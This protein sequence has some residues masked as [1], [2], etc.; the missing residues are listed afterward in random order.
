MQVLAQVGLLRS[1]NVTE[2]RVWWSRT[3]AKKSVWQTFFI[4]LLNGGESWWSFIHLF[5]VSGTQCWVQN[6]YFYPWST[7]FLKIKWKF[8]ELSVTDPACENLHECMPTIFMFNI[9]VH[10]TRCSL[11]ARFLWIVASNK[12]SLR[13]PILAAKLTQNV[14]RQHRH[15]DVHF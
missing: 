4:F 10:Y 3:I 5:L 14:Q 15:A 2:S 8:V 12:M 11:G 7:L 9:H 13:D 1:Y 6:S